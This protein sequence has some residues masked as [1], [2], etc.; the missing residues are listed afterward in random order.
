MY[1]NE[2]DREAVRGPE[3]VGT[4]RD[5]RDDL[6]TDR[7]ESDLQRKQSEGN[8]GNERTRTRPDDNRHDTPRE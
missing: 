7:E 2:S 3:D 8:L 4:P 6:V 5:E 1:R